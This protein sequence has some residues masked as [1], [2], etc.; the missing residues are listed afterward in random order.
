MASTFVADRR[1]QRYGQ[2]LAADTA[3]PKHS[4]VVS[5]IVVSHN[6]GKW[7]RKTVNSLA[8]T[9]PPGGEILVVDDHSTD[10][11]AARLLSQIGV[12]VLRPKRRLGAPRARNFAAQRAGGPILVFCDAH[13][14]APPRWFPPFRAVLA[15]PKAGLVGPAYTEMNSREEKYFGLGF[16]DAGLNCD[17]L[18]QLSRSPYEVPL[19]GGFF[20]GI[21]RELFF[22][23]GGFDPGFGF[24]GMEDVE[25]VMRIWGLGYR[26]ILVPSVEVAHLDGS[27]R[28]R[29]EDYQGDQRRWI[30]TTLRFAVL[31]FGEL[32]LRHV[33]RFYARDPYFPA[34]L[35]GLAVSDA[36]EKRA[37]IHAE[38]TR[39][40]EWFFQRFAR[41][42]GWGN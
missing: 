36:W 39:G 26:C 9:I 40:D 18:D 35:A 15:R 19:L 30:E 12:S 10:G 34:A 17:G 24:W 38:R 13:I 28:P 16:I 37:A 41:R 6:E 2:I 42:Q 7:L 4:P 22:E 25:L 1:S 5:V 11:S 32:R 20:L 3:F 29:A 14:E 8:R 23:I 21:R 31:H 27:F 33:F